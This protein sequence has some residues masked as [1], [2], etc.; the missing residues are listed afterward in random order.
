MTCFCE[1]LHME[2]RQTPTKTIDP[3]QYLQRC[4]GHGLVKDPSREVR[5]GVP[6]K[7]PLGNEAT[8]SKGTDNT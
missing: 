4:Q 2:K 8:Q 5:E 7:E 6:I 1:A 3:R